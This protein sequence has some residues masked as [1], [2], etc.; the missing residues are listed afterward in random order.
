MKFLERFTKLVGV[1]I[2]ILFCGLSI[3]FSIIERELTDDSLR[4]TISYASNFENR[5]YDWRMKSHLDPTNK[6]PEVVLA[7]IDDESL[8]KIGSWPIPRNIWA[9]FLGKLKIYGAK[10]VGFDV[11]FPEPAMVCNATSP[12]DIFRDAIADFQSIEGNKIIMAYT[13]AEHY[14]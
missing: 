8:Q 10:I 3:F 14:E 13:L 12:D 7:R 5:F 6:D 11:M 1:V 2:I 9:H 4:E